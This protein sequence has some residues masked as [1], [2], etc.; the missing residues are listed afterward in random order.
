M[1]VVA[2][3]E[4]TGSQNVNHLLYPFP[5]PQPIT[6]TYIAFWQL[7]PMHR[8][9]NTVSP[10]VKKK[11]PQV[12][13]NADHSDVVWQSYRNAIQ[14]VVW[15][16]YWHL[17]IFPWQHHLYWT[18]CSKLLAIHPKI[19][20]DICKLDLWQFPHQ[21]RKWVTPLAVFGFKTQQQP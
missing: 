16:N 6:I 8:L 20:A 15:R 21:T 14:L 3:D 13:S 5:N 12:N 19:M 10:I 17:L 1:Q 11:N 4:D 9:Q 18:L 7:L 2:Y